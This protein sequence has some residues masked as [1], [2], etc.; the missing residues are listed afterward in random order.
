MDGEWPGKVPARRPWR[1]KVRLKAPDHTFLVLV[2]L[3]I[4]LRFR[5]AGSPM[6][7]SWQ[8]ID[9]LRIG[10]IYALVLEAFKVG[11]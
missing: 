7:L 3:L 6:S 2:E 10:F 5:F 11:S 9:N 1:G 8:V 4:R